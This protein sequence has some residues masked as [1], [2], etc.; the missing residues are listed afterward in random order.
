MEQ[1]PYWEANM[2]P[3]SQYRTH[4]SPPPVPILS[5]SNQFMSSISRFEDPF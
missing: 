3:K 5:Q 1:S 4:K 2:N